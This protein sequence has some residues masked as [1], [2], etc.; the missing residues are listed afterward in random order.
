[1][2]YQ[3]G[4]IY[5]YTPL[6][7][8]E[9]LDATT[10]QKS[11]QIKLLTANVLQKNEEKNHLVSLIEKADADLLLFTETDQKWR[12]A[13]VEGLS[14]EYRYRVEIP[15]DNT[16]GMLMYSKF[17]L[18]NPKKR[19][20]VDDSIP[21]IQTKLRLPSGDLIEVLAIHPTPPMPQENPKSSERDREMMLT[22]FTARQSDLPVMVIGDFNDVSWSQTTILFQTISGLLDP[23]IGRGFYNTFSAKNP[24][25]R[26]PLDH[27]F[28][29]PE[30]RLSSVTVG[31]KINSDHFP[32]L[33]TLSLE[34]NGASEQTPE[35]PSEAD[36]K[37]AKD[38]MKENDLLDLGID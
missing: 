38:Q 2:I 34:P 25:L 16:Y 6:A 30:F 8:Y 19:Y 29:S 26:W 4:K 5:L 22:A 37:D 33:A 21:S 9:L 31:E 3:F 24:I 12:D 23:R 35:P 20:Q 7:S 18:I 32:L 36:L 13:I 27:I 10:S 17:E 14:S 11:N 28:V 1:M 15:L